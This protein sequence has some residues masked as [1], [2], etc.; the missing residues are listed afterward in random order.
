M[1]AQKNTLPVRRYFVHAEKRQCE[2][3]TSFAAGYPAHAEICRHAMI[4][5]LIV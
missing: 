5:A 2:T 1:S 3:W 4:R